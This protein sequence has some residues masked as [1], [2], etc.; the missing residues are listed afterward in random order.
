MKCLI[1]VCLILW[2]RKLKQSCYMFCIES[3]KHNTFKGIYIYTLY[4]YSFSKSILYHVRVILSFSKLENNRV[5]WFLLK[6]TVQIYFIPHLG[7]SF[8]E[9]NRTTWMHRFYFLCVFSSITSVSTVQTILDRNKFNIID[10]KGP[11]LSLFVIAN[12]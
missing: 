8:L 1:S 9:D 7:A 10:N 6:E 4:I 3:R 2:L 11:S 12:Q 5:Y